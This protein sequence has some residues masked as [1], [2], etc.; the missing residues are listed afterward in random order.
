[1]PVPAYSTLG[2]LPFDWLADPLLNT[3]IDYPEGEL[4]RLIFHELAHQ[5][6]Y[7]AGDTSFNESFATAVERIGGER[8]LA[9]RASAAGA[10][11]VRASRREA[12]RLP[13]ADGEVP[14]RARRA[15]PQRRVGCRQAQPQGRAVRGAARRVRGAEAASAGAGFQGTTA[16]F[17]RANNASLGVLAAYN[18]Q[19]PAFHAPVR[20]QRRRFRAL[21]R[22]GQAAR[23]A[24][25]ER[26]ARRAR[27]LGH[28][29]LRG[30]RGRHPNST[31][32]IS[33]VCRRRARSPG[34]GP[35]TSRS[36]SRWS[37]P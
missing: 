3:F 16:W 7:A 1:M 22:R 12:P 25:P 24:E 29:S 15:L 20:A 28:S 26:T 18:D 31:R 37:A 32:H 13:R 21:L 14:E 9:T 19:V 23:G 2:A 36:A 4:A 10:R 6:A 27:T 5:I 33:S 30:F 34:N 8:W 11:R 35:R 17:A